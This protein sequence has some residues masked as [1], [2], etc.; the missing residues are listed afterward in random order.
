MKTKDLQKI[1][2]FS[3]TLGVISIIAGFILFFHESSQTYRS[4]ELVL[5]VLGAI[6]ISIG[7]ISQILHHKRTTGIKAT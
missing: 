3:D 4:I 5:F 7:I 2:Y 1:H 6:L